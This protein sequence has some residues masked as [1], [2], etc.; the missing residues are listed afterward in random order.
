MHVLNF[1]PSRFPAHF[2]VCRANEGTHDVGTLGQI[3]AELNKVDQ[4]AVIR[5][6]EVVNSSLIIERGL[7]LSQ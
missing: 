4:L 7:Q 2:I 1:D 5:D 3:N 6:E